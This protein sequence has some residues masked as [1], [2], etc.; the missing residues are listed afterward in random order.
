MILGKWQLNTSV[1][2]FYHNSEKY[3]DLHI[4]NA[5]AN[6]ICNVY[7]IWDFLPK[8]IRTCWLQFCNW[9]CNFASNRWSILFLAL[10]FGNLS[11][12]LSFFANCWK[13]TI[14]LLTYFYE[15]LLQKI[16]WSVQCRIWVFFL[17]IVLL[18]LLSG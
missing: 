7:M 17:N 16:H 3:W 6:A 15:C 1:N 5:I 4:I 2:G 18:K 13:N 8:D 10:F 9:E 12:V 14:C 11:I